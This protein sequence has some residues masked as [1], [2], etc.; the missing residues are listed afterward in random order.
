MLRR[1]E[2]LRAFAEARLEK[3]PKTARFHE[4]RIDVAIVDADQRQPE[5]VRCA[6]VEARIDR[7]ATLVTTLREK[8]TSL[9]LGPSG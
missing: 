6:R 5:D 8:A 7:D 3:I 2:G 9:R 1:A 4:H